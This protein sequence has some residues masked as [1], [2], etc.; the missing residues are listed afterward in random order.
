[1]QR[2]KLQSPLLALLVAVVLLAGCGAPPEGTDEA[3]TLEAPTLT[4]YSGRSE[5]LV[6][7]LLE[8]FEQDTGIAVEV[9]YGSTAE[10]ANLLM[11]EGD[12]SPADAFFA[13]DGGALGSVSAAGML[14]PLRQ[15][16]LEK[17]EA[18]FRSPAGDWIGL[19]G[20]ARVVVYNTEQVTPDE[21]PESLDA[22]TDPAYRGRFGIAPTNASFQA[23]MAVYAAL[24]G[25]D[26]LAELLEGI[27]AN[28]PRTYDGNTALVAA[29]IAGEI[30]FGLTNHYY[31]WNARRERP[32]APA[33]NRFMP[34]GD[35]SSFVNVAG[36]GLLT[37]SDAAHRLI[38]YLV[39]E[40]GQTYFATETFEYPL[41][42]GFGP[43]ANLV[44]LGE[45]RTPDID[46]VRVGELL[47]ATLQ[48]ISE[49]GLTP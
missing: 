19:S 32:G 30:D 24:H 29:T 23:H 45:L 47:P 21:L 40:P 10:L 42:D 28:E 7:A 11:E 34:A 27:A 9:R 25:T 20:R 37:D 4:V 14:V 48:L 35:A 5:R 1:M 22:V 49:S 44:P 39:S 43:A 33:A 13:Q 41:V 17:V 8:Q 26:A 16:S 2:A 3:D 38:E 46:F 36:I 12:A 15:D 31:L 6:G 18:R